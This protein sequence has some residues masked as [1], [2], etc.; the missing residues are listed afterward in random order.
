MFPTLF[1]STIYE[2]ELSTFLDATKSFSR[3]QSK[4]RYKYTIAHEKLSELK[5]TPTAKGFLKKTGK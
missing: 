3:S 5:C 4:E 2:Q 1:D